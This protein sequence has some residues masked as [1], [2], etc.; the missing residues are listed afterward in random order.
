MLTKLLRTA[1][2][3]KKKRLRRNSDTVADHVTAINGH[4]EVE[5]VVNKVHGQ[6]SNDHVNDTNKVSKSEKRR[7]K[8]V[9][10]AEDNF[11]D[12]DE[13]KVKKS[14]KAK[15]P[16]TGDE[17]IEYQDH[18]EPVDQI[19]DEE[20]DVDEVDDNAE[21]FTI[22][23]EV[24]AMKPKPLKTPLPKW[25]R[26]PTI[27][28]KNI[29]SDDPPEYLAPYLS[30]SLIE[31]LK[32][33]GVSHL[34]PVQK[35]IIPYLC[36]SFKAARSFRPSDICVSSPTGSGKTLAF[37]LPV[38]NSLQS[39]VE[40]ALRA[41]VVLPVRDL[42][43]QVH[44][45]FETYCK[46][47]SLR[48]G[49]AVGQRSFQEDVDNLI[50]LN[51]DSSY[52][53]AVDILVCTPGRLVD[54]I[55]RAKGFDL[56]KLKYLIVDE[57]DRIMSSELEHHWL[58]EVEKAVHGNPANNMNVPCLCGHSKTDHRVSVECQ[59]GCA[60]SNYSNRTSSVQKLLFSATLSNDP[61]KLQS[62]KL[63]QPKLFIAS[64]NEK[65]VKTTMPTELTEQMIITAEDK[66][67]LVLWYLLETLK[68][69]RM[70]IFTG[71]IENTHRLY[72][73]LKNV[74]DV[75][76]AECAS[77]LAPAKREQLLKQ[78]SDNLVD[79]IICSDMMARGI[80]LTNV[81]YVVCYDPPTNDTAY[82]HRIGRTARAG[83]S[84]VA[85][86]LLTSKQIG[87]FQTVIR[88]AHQRSSTNSSA[89]NYGVEKFAIKESLL[90]KLVPKY[91]EALKDLSK[92][93]SKEDRNTHFRKKQAV[94]E[95]KNKVK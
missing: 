46:G 17:T 25:I 29:T 89:Q 78:F 52:R 57:A 18:I 21:Q 36:K 14:K 8:A 83:K 68:Y 55:Q 19:N 48:V 80:D 91:K 22:I 30:D 69:R 75:K 73:L 51:R 58:D 77:Y 66:K 38:I 42:A 31:Q 10:I 4:I 84:G 64:A 95:K 63:F 15:P 13:P 12:E 87:L 35:S 59:V 23:G 43:L 20:G 6:Q 37:T 3:R 94:P 27:F 33:N 88:R 92:S 70:L 41:L 44:H 90:K 74:D 71:S 7:T 67:P 60:L 47:S 65:S 49:L 62:M 32:T 61:V 24:K 53:S 93:V 54:L 82:I 40:T 34:F 56:T 85:I 45:V 1:E 39:R 50:R 9:K 26:E 28:D 79:V 76:V 2:K 16:L 5:E 86:T 81:S 11:N 72:K